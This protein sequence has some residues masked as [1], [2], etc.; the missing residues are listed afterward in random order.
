[1][2]LFSKQRLKNSRC[3]ATVKTLGLITHA[4]SGSRSVNSAHDSRNS[5]YSDAFYF[6]GLREPACV[7]MPGTTVCVLS[8][9]DQARFFC[10][11]DKAQEEHNINGL[12]TGDQR[13]CAY[14]LYPR[15]A[16]SLCR[17]RKRRLTFT[18]SHAPFTAGAAKKTIPS[19]A[20]KSPDG[21]STAAPIL[22]PSFPEVQNDFQ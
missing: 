3:G 4:N 9:P 14:E 22:T 13:Q 2:K 17:S 7:S 19:P 8:T 12:Q 10:A 6:A 1:M 21:S 5:Y 11:R 15:P 16:R 20:S 18:A